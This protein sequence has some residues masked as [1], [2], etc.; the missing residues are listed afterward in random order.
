[1]SE[2][3][4]YGHLKEKPDAK[5]IAA[6]TTTGKGDIKL[7]VDMISDRT[8]ML[9]DVR[10]HAGAMLVDLAALMTFVAKQE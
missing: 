10:A 1:M 4:R 3:T 9:A 8:A 2:W 5:T 7:S 6:L